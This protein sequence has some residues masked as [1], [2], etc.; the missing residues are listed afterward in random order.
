MEVVIQKSKKADKK[1]DAIIDGK[2][3]IP[4]GSKM[5]SDF[6]LH[7]DEARKQRYINRHEKRE[8]LA[9]TQKLQD[10]IAAGCYG[11]RTTLK[12]SVDDLNKRYKNINFIL[13][14]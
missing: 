11:T 12:E 9:M 14:N 8:Q 7:K 2:K 1:F 13:R 6:T 4:F 3:T 5:H 10:S